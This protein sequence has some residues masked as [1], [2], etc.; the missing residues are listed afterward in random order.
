MIG[1]LLVE[2]QTHGVGRASCTGAIRKA[3]FRARLACAVLCALA[4]AGC[5][6]VVGDLP[7]YSG[8]APLAADA[9]GYATDLQI[10]YFGAGSVLLRR[11]PDAVLTAPFFSNPSI[12]R[13]AFGTIH[14][15]H[16]E[17]DRFLWPL[18]AELS[19]IR[20]VLV[21]HAHYD[22]L[23][24]VPYAYA[25][26]FPIAKIYGSDTAKNILSAALPDDA[27]ESVESIAGNAQR[28]GKWVQVS[29]R[30][31]FMALQS[32]HAPL[33]LHLRYS[34]HGYSHPLTELPVRGEGWRQGE[35]LAYLIE[36]LADDE[37]TVAFRVHYQDAASTPPLGF[38]PETAVPSNSARTDVAILCVPGFDQV[39]DYPTKVIERLKP[40]HVVGI[41]WENFFERLPD[42]VSDLRTVPTL[43]L[44]KFIQAVNAVNAGGTFTLTAPGAWLRIPAR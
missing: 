27:V 38:P 32:E 34:P 9:P 28:A 10:H 6:G 41:H 12:W 25:K 36:F 4:F 15:R 29:P 26:Y 35:A 1:T 16:D 5:G 7:L 33:Y 44:H 21:G 20:A 31:R 42:D 18:R 8:G 39:E 17:V 14:S 43:D 11:G 2:A 13:V 30:L 37:K 19:G 3:W 23:L 22:H 24:D 40:L